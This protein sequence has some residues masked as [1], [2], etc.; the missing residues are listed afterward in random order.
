MIKSLYLYSRYFLLTL[1][2]AKAAYLFKELYG[3]YLRGNRYFANKHVDPRHRKLAMARAV[4]WLLHA[5]KSTPDDGMGSFHLVNKWSASYP[6]TSGYIIPTLLQYAAFN[7]DKNINEAAVKAADWLVS[8]QKASGGWQGGRVNENRPEIVFNTAQ[9]IRGLMAVFQLTRDE[10]YFESA[11]RAGDWLCDIQDGS[12]TWI[13]NALMGKA[14]VYDSYVDYP[15]LLL[16]K[17]TKAEKYR[18]H[19]IRNLDWIVNE[20]QHKNGWFE[21]CDNTIKRNDKPILHTIA[22]TI[23]GLLDCGIYLDDRKYI[24]A[25]R[26]A[27]D[28]L[29]DKF[30]RNGF[31]HGRYDH[32]WEGSENMILTGC[33]QMSII[34]LKIAH[35]SGNT[36]YADTAIKMNTL[37]AHLQNRNF[38]DKA[39]DTAGGLSGSYP[40]WGRYEPFA[41]PNWATKYFADAMILEEGHRK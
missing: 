10:K 1:F 8:I 24:D 18:Q 30:E 34:W 6:E 11:T 17:Q 15:L 23:D 29:K 13:Q 21:D 35:Y 16:H 20:K 14:R 27:A 28:M 41:Y 39:P 37:L 36:T 38:Q 31:L 7:N 2:S 9:I 3:Y 25:A 26:K 19:A 33:A 5:Q 40:L 12:G 32:N 4:S 22:Y